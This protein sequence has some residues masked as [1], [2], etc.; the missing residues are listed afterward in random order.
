[1]ARTSPKNS[2]GNWLLDHLAP[3]AQERI[4]AQLVPLPLIANH[5]I[6]EPGEAATEAVFPTS[7][8]ISLVSMME[9]G[10]SVE[11]GMI[12]KEGMFGASMVLGDDRPQQRAMVQLEGTALK[13]PVRVLRQEIEA[14]AGWKGLLL[15]YA[16]VTLTTATQAAACNRLHLL[17]QRFARWPLA[18]HDRAER[19]TFPL[20]HEFL[21][22]MLGV[23]RPGVTVAAQSLQSD[24][25]ISYNHGTMTIVDRKGLEATSCECYRTI[26]QEMKRLLGLSS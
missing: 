1:M 13:M 22:M 9:D 2:F 15:L 24:G 25:I 20:T 8:L 7:G 23:R 26:Q 17:E 3:A 16:Q 19:D 21:A 5:T 12:G 14:D 4:R 10:T 11:V 18:A 6:H